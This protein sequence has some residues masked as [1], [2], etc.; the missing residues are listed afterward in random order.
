MSIPSYRTRKEVGNL[1]VQARAVNTALNSLV[2]GIGIT[3]TRKIFLN[4]SI[5]EFH[6]VHFWIR[7]NQRYSK[8]SYISA[9]NESWLYCGLSHVQL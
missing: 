5:I 3:G 8:A 1:Q 2:M 6:A 4:T 9:R 7:D